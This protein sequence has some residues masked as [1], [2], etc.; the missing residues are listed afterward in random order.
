MTLLQIFK[1]HL[2]TSNCQILPLHRRQPKLPIDQKY[3]LEKN[4]QVAKTQILRIIS[5]ENTKDAQDEDVVLKNL[6]N[7]HNC[8]LYELIHQHIQVIPLVF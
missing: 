6:T 4:Q 7:G 1:S 8:K 3:H 5:V 2:F